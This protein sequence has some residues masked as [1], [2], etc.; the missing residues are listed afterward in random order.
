ME[1][2]RNYLNDYRAE[3][4]A[5]AV[6]ML[7]EASSLFEKYKNEEL[8]EDEKEEIMNSTIE[9]EDNAKSLVSVAVFIDEL[10]ERIKTNNFSINFKGEED[11][12]E[13]REYEDDDKDDDKDE[14]KYGD[15]EY[16]KDDEEEYEDGKYEENE[17]EEY[18]EGND[19]DDEDE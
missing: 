2:L 3:A 10:L 17:N 1:E 11:E 9:L 4:K 5:E 15:E 12:D 18:A 13:D 19:E 8:E 14:E 6:S 16:A 7:E